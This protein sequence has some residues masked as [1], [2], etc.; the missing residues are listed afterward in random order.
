MG[1]AKKG[2]SRDGVTSQPPKAWQ[3]VN[4]GAGLLGQRAVLKT[5]LPYFAGEGPD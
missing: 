1:K 4:S 2:E 5:E 3:V